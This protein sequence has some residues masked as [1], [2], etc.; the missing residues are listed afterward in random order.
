[1]TGRPQKESE[2]KV[3]LG[4][5][6]ARALRDRLGEPSRVLSQV[7]LF[8][9]TAEDHLARAGVCLRIREE[10]AAA[11]PEGDDAPAGGAERILLTVKEAG[12]RAGALMVRPEVESEIARSDWEDLR[13]RRRHFAELDLAPVGRL[14]EILGRLDG[15]DLAP[16]GRIENRREVY[17]LRTEG[18]AFEVLLDR[19]V[20]PD[21]AV[22]FELESELPE[23]A[24]GEGARALRRLFEELGIEW[25]PADVGKYVRFR[26][27]I[28]RDPD[29]AGA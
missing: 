16:L 13:L 21:G 3:L 10:S 9:D 27:K 20:Y 26:R 17:D 4:D 22:E 6:D 29:A 18:M 7:S 28:G 1:M 19:T 12:L 5:E 25:R 2:I 24:A 15:L 23:A 8:Y 14:R 11:A